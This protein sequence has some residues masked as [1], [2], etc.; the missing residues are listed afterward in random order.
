MMKKIIDTILAILFFLFAVV[1]F[2]DPDPLLWIAIY[3][4]VGLVSAGAFFDKYHQYALI[5]LILIITVWSL[6]LLPNV[7]TWLTT[8]NLDELSGEMMSDK[9]YIEGTREFGGLLIA[10]LA[11]VYH[12]VVSRKG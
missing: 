10:D 2:N 11:L 3:G 6:I 4:I 7:F 9:P 5:S 1:Q 8:S 12:W